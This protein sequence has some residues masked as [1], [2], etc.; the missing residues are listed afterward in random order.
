VE[1]VESAILK[2]AA[3]PFSSIAELITLPYPTWGGRQC[4]ALK[5]GSESGANRTG[6]Y[7]LGGVH[8]REWG[9]SDILINFIESI[10]QAYL[11]NTPLTFGGKTFGAAEIKTIVD[12]LDIVIFPQ[13]NPDGKHYSMTAE[14]DWR[15]NRRA[16]P[17]GS[18]QCPGVDINRNYDFLWDFPRHFSPAFLYKNLTSTTPCNDY[19]HGESAFS[20]PETRNARW[21]VDTFANTRFFIDL[22]SFGPQILYRWGD[23]QDQTNNPAMNFMNPKY[24]GLRGDDRSYS[25]YLPASDLGTMKSLAAALHDGIKAVRGTDY[26]IGTAYNYYTTAGASDDYFYSRH[27]TDP[28]RAKIL[29]YTL[30]WGVTFQPAH[31]EMRRIIDEITAGLLTFCLGIVAMTEARGTA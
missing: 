20:E 15:K 25:E 5:I 27:F 24:N 26:S 17:L 10:E 31:D 6:L 16:A 3:A 7:F 19:Y 11:N 1:E 4:H 21:I 14:S 2:A 22:H 13:A 12:T 18:Q 8:A 29:S 28:G 9:S 30:E 23:G